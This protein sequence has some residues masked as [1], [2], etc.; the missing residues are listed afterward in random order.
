M[1]DRP[2]AVAVAAAVEGVAE[3]D[4]VHLQVDGVP[5]GSPQHRR[6]VG[7]EQVELRPARVLPGD[8]PDDLG[9]DATVLVAWGET[10]A[11]LRVTQVV[12]AD[13]FRVVV[14]D[15]DGVGR[16]KGT[17]AIDA[18]EAVIEDSDL[19]ALDVAEVFVLGHQAELLF[20]I[21]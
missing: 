13:E 6:P 14:L 21:G 12:P 3:Q 16:K 4:Q 20:D 10:L 18:V 19:D 11:K 8:G 1:I 17:G 15:Q 9:H 5:D 7:I 2:A